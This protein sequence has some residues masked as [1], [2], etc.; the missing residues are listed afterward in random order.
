ASQ[1]TEDR[2]PAASPRDP[3]NPTALPD[4]GGAVSAP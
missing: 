3:S 4:A 2:S 1:Q